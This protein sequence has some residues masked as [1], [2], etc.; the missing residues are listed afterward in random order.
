MK[1]SRP[2]TPE[3][4][5]TASKTQMEY[6]ERVKKIAQLTNLTAIQINMSWSSLVEQGL[7]RRHGALPGPEHCSM[8]RAFVLKRERP[9]PIKPKAKRL[10][11]NTKRIDQLVLVR[12]PPES[13]EALGME[14][15]AAADLVVNLTT[16]EVIKNRFGD[17]PTQETTT[18]PTIP[19]GVIEEMPQLQPLSVPVGEG[20]KY[21]GVMVWAIQQCGT[22]R[23]ARNAFERAFKALTP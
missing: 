8:I 9:E 21:V 11:V 10:K 12:V 6:W 5:L 18:P 4:K 13:K 22:L 20:A 1:K 2:K 19:S 14:D 7:V 23:A 3:E 16:G 15:I 17:K